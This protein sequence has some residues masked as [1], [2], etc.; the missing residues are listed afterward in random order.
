VAPQRWDPTLPKLIEV[1]TTFN[2]LYTQDAGNNMPEPEQPK[3]DPT[4]ERPWYPPFINIWG[5]LEPAKAKP[6]REE[7]THY[8]YMYGYPDG[9]VQPNGQITRAEA[10]AV[11]ARLENLP[12]V[13]NSAP[14]F[15]DT[16]SDSDWYNSVINAVVKAGLMRG[17]PDGSFKPESSITRAEFAQMIMPIDKANSAFAPFADVRGHWA[18]KAI[19]Q[20]YGNNRIHGYP[21]G[22]FRP[23]GYITRAEAAKI[24]NSLYDRKVTEVGLANVQNIED[25]KK[26]TDLNRS[27]WAY[28]ELVEATN[29]HVYYRLEEGRIDEAWIRIITDK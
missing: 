9:S 19:N 15:I 8:A 3:P 20:A 1:D 27:H 21:E 10:A 14:N 26:F 28:Y 7:G 22:D 12:I 6:V 23:D 17:Y 5:P 18:E 11:L 16:K 24:L 29:S 25:L 2:A 13:D 4:P